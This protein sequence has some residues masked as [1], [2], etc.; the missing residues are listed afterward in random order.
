MIR[1]NDRWRTTD[2]PAALTVA[3]EGLR[4]VSPDAL[5]ILAS[6][7][8]TVEEYFLLRR[9]AEHLGCANVDH[10]LGATDV[11]VQEGAGS[12]PDLGMSIA[13]WERV[14]AALIIGSDLRREIP[15]LHLRLRK[16]GLR[17]ARLSVINPLDGDFRFPVQVSRL[18]KDLAEELAALVL[19]VSELTGNAIPAA[20]GAAVQG[21]E[22]QQ[23]HVYIAEDLVR[24]AQTGLLVGQLALDQAGAGT[25]LALAAFVAEATGSALGT[26]PVGGNTAG[27]WLCGIVP[28][29]GVG[30]TPVAAPG[31]S[32]NEMLS[33]TLQGFLLLGAEP[34]REAAN[35]AAAV[36]ALSG[37][38]FGVAL[39]PYLT[40]TLKATA[41]VLLPIGTF[42]ETAG[43]LISRDGQWLSFEGCAE[44]IGAA[45]P[46][47]KV[48]RVLGNSLDIAGFDYADCSEVTVA[49]RLA[50]GP[51]QATPGQWHRQGSWERPMLPALQRL[52]PLA[53]YGTDVLGRRAPCL[54]DSPEGKRARQLR[55]HPTDAARA[56]LKAGE[57]VQVNQAGARVVASWTADA[58]LAPGCVWF[59]AGLLD[60]PVGGAR[61]GALEILPAA[62]D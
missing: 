27:A 40:E 58:T 50:I 8:A 34:E 53:L 45:R 12:F 19:A 46:G 22:P 23:A 57:P 29:R 60:L 6:P 44:P 62:A 61:F 21:V 4:R 13:A 9:L 48:L 5:G 17:G 3:A 54:Q 25:L 52:G 11:A 33:G 55:I 14:D 7:S 18:A 37:A 35:P 30:G 15:L 38:A 47:W 56:G 59:P 28:H 42:S 36:A 51:V 16:A 24:G 32:A 39:T 41:H 2:W 10:R 31:R 1:E 49:A 20:L 43:S 26:L